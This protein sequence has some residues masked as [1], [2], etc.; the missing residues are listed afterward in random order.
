MLFDQYEY[1][2]AYR[3]LKKHLYFYYRWCTSRQRY[4]KEVMVN[5]YLLFVAD[6]KEPLK[7]RPNSSNGLVVLI[8]FPV[9]RFNRGFMSAQHV[10]DNTTSYIFF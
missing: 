3:T 8:R 6:G 5:R 9:Y 4:V 7:L 1:K 10:H 2:Q